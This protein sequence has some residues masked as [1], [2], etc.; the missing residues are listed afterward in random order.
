MPKKSSCEI[1]TRTIHQ[2]QKNGDIY[3]IER[4]TQYDP[5]KKYNVVISSR[6]IGKIPKGQKTMVATRPK[7]RSKEKVSNSAMPPAVVSA[8]RRKV[9]MMNIIDHIG[10]ISRIDD[11]VYNNTDLGTAQKILS[12]ARYLLATNGR[13]YRASLPGNTHIHYRTRMVSLKTPTMNS[14]GRL[15]V[16]RHLCRIFLRPALRTW[17]ARFCLHMTLHYDF[18]LFGPDI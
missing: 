6:I 11:A 16:T 8:S 17:A 13:P 5:V 9:G 1:K 18:N 12:L 10:K 2:T 14:L 7:R 15:G 3:V 4:Q